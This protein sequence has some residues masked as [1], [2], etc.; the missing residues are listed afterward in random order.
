MV[1][2]EEIKSENL[3]LREEAVIATRPEEVIDGV[4]GTGRVV[5]VGGGATNGHFAGGD[6]GAAVAHGLK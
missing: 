5:M 6:V 1:R 2:E 4:V 3:D